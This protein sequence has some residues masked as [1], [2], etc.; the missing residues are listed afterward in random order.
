MKDSDSDEVDSYNTSTNSLD[1]SEEIDP[2]EFFTVKELCYYKLIDKYFKKCDNENIKKMI[3]IINGTS[4]IS[5]RVLDWVVTKFSKKKIDVKKNNI[6]MFDVR[7][8]YRSQL[9]SYKKRYFDPFRRRK[10]FIYHFN[11]DES[12]SISTTLGQL[13]FFKWAFINNVIIYVEK[14][15]EYI[16][17][18]M[19]LS[20]KEE[21][22]KK[23]QKENKKS[24]TE[25][26]GSVKINAVKKITDDEVQI[27]LIFD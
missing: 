17:K 6:E 21:K 25:S 12:N 5:L 22:H 13:N 3:D 15:L 27:T 24:D 9:K 8:S 16:G 1:K 20:N 2:I 7:I 14:N 10:K 4:V 18:E 11:D 26:K 19:N 23:K